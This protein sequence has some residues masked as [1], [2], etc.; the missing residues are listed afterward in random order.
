MP[1]STQKLHRR[2]TQRIILGELEL[3]S[4]HAS[5]KRCPFGSLYESF[6]VEH[7]IFGDGAGGNSFR[8]VGGEVFV[9]VEEALLRYVGAHF[10]LLR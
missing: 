4:K 9:F 1:N 3:R 10:A 5:F 2:R 6:P 7:V 8:R